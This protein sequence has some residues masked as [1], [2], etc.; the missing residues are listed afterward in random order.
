LCGGEV[1]GS[2]THQQR[3]HDNQQPIFFQNSFRTISI[4][5]FRYGK[6]LG[7]ASPAGGEF[8]GVAEIKTDVE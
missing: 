3:K 7:L 2:E 6:Q 5:P 1:D 4:T 8:V